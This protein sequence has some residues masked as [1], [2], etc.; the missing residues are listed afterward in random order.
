M[1]ITTLGRQAD[2]PDVAD[3]FVKAVVVGATLYLLDGSLGGAAAAAGV[4]LTLTLA[5]SLADTVI[6]DYAGNV[7]FGAVV[8]GGAVYF[9]TLGSVRFPVALVVVG[10]WLLFDGVQHLR[11]GVT[12]DEVGVPYRH[13][14]SVLTG[15]PKALF[16]RLL[17]PFRL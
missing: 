6:G 2:G 5:T 11:H 13:D 12:R 7:L 9:A 8:L 4:F 14:G 1:S 3:T 10:G 16:A 15:L 17:E